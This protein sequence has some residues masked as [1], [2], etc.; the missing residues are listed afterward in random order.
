MC[1]FV[2]RRIIYPFKD[3]TWLAIQDVT[4]FIQCFKSQPFN[5]AIFQ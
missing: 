4:N 3:I 2:G 5:P 1:L